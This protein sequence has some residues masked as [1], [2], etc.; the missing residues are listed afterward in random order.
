MD[1]TQRYNGAISLIKS[2]TNYTAEEAT[3]KLKQWEGN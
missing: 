3:V 2:Q 1:K